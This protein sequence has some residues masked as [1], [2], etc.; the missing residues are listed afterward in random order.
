MT[1]KSI[2]K[3]SQ[4]REQLPQNREQDALKTVGD[5]TGDQTSTKQA[6]PAFF[7]DD[8]FRRV[9]CDNPLQVSGLDLAN[10]DLELWSAD[11][12]R[13]WSRVPADMS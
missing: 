6:S 9:D 7:L 8:L 1:Q 4:I 10:I 3:N 13:R 11:R 2:P 12:I 5:I